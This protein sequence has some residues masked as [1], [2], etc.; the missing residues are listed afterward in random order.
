[1][2]E[3]LAQRSTGWFEARKGRIT[4]SRVPAILGHSAYR[5]RDDVLREMIREAYGYER[6]FQGNTATQWGTDNE[7]RARADYEAD[8]GLWVDDVGLIVHPEHDWLAASPDGLIEDDGYLEIKCPYSGETKSKPEWE[9]QVQFGLHVTGRSWGHLYIWTPTYAQIVTVVYESEFLE[10]NWE[11]LSR[12][13]DDFRAAAEDEE[14]ARPHLEPLVQERFDEE[15]QEAAE[16][17]RL[18]KQRK[19]RAEEELKSARDRLVEL[20]GDKAAQGYGVKVQPITKSGG[21]DYKKA[22]QDAGADLEQYRKPE[23]TE[24]RVNVQE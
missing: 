17:F 18:A 15:W 10:R 13:L 12:F 23:R 6:E 2:T 5:S 3:Q 9:L 1:M 22:A 11:D 14:T 24:W 19:E 16:A 7:A 20:A 4:A 21:L 8:T